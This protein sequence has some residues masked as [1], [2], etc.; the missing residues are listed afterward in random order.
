MA[1]SISVSALAVALIG[2]GSGIVTG[3]L[4]WHIYGLEPNPNNAEYYLQQIQDLA[5]TPEGQDRA[6]RRC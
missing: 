2:A 1:D 3:H 5:L 6:A 4:M